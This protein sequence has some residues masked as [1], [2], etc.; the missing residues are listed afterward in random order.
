MSKLISLNEVKRRSGVSYPALLRYRDRMLYRCKGPANT[1]D[2]NGDWCG[3]LAKFTT[4]EKTSYGARVLFDP[5][6]IP[7]FLREKRAGLAKRG[8]PPKPRKGGR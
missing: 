5:A 8:R 1:P 4:V 7:L 2:K 3:P 6:C